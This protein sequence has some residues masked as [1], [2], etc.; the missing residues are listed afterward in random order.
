MYILLLLLFLLLLLLLSSLFESRMGEI[1]RNETK[2]ER[3]V[4]EL[5]PVS[6]CRRKRISDCEGLED[7]TGN[8]ICFW[9]FD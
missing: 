7:V 4:I 2:F 8:V 1:G 5:V 3:M 6:S 9:W